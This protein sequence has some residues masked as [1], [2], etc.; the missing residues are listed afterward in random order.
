MR[1]LKLFFIVS[2]ITIIA[3]CSK[4]NVVEK[5]KETPINIQK[6]LYVKNGILVFNSE[7]SFD[8]TLEKVNKMA[9]DERKNWEINLG[10]KSF[11]R[12]LSEIEDDQ[13][14]HQ[15]KFAHLF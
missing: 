11:V 3:A 2:F 13:I 8:K 7:K 10:F 5:A 12:T 14:L 1:V 6:K 9:D 4:E 15:E